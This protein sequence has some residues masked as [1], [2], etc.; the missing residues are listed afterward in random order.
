ML[1]SAVETAAVL[2]ARTEA[3]PRD[4]LEASIPLL[5]QFLENRACFDLIDPIAVI[6]S[7]YTGAT[8]KFIDFLVTFSPSPPTERPVEFL[9]FSFEAREIKKAASIIYEHRSEALHN[10][11]AFPLPMCLPPQFFA[12]EGKQGSAHAEVPLGLATYSLGASWKHKQTPM[13]LHTFE[14]IARGA[15]LGWWKS[16]DNNQNQV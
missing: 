1:I 15:L 7:K 10:G 9:R 4:R 14:Y 12:V 8:K 2:W 3:S 16:L 11:T 13:L 6:L 5:F